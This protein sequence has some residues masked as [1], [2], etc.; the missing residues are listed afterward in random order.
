MP[1]LAPEVVLW[2]QSIDSRVHHRSIRGLFIEKPEEEYTGIRVSEKTL[3]RIV[4]RHQFPEEE[5][6]ES[7]Q[8]ISLDTG[9]VPL[10]TATKREP[11]TWKDDKAICTDKRVRKPT[12]WENEALIEWVNRQELSKTVG[13]S[14]IAEA[15]KSVLISTAIF[16]SSFV[17]PNSLSAP[18]SI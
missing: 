6:R 2:V 3:Q 16:S 7:I 1:D 9:K 4:H 17:A 18:K 5:V 12:F 11:Y 13:N 15:A 14:E 8:E 10:R